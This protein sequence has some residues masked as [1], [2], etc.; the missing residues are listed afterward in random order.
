MLVRVG[1]TLQPLIKQFQ[2][3]QLCVNNVFSS[4]N[5]EVGH[6]RFTDISITLLTLTACYKCAGLPLLHTSRLLFHF[7]INNQIWCTM[8]LYVFIHY[9]VFHS[10][11]ENTNFE[12]SEM[13]V[14]YCMYVHMCW[15]FTVQCLDT[16]SMWSTLQSYTL[17]NITILALFHNFNFNFMIEFFWLNYCS[18]SR[19]LHH[20]LKIEKKQLLLARLFEH[21]I[22]QFMI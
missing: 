10:K 18:I 17:P 16:Y 4:N 5:A 14:L 3:L 12:M 11:S 7:F 20:V 21:H 15:T 6:M 22:N 8:Y 1:K 9:Y 13:W 19:G 2:N